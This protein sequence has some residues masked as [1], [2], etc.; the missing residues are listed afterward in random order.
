M[1]ALATCTRWAFGIALLVISPALLI[2]AVPF[3]AG[4][5][6]DALT[7]S[8]APAG[9]SLTLAGCTAALIFAC[10]ARGRSRRRK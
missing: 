7:L 3:A 4:A 10:L 8:G 6:A 2:F 9:L 5:T 1:A